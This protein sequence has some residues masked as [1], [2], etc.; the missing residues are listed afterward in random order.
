MNILGIPAEQI[1]VPPSPPAMGGIPT[2]LQKN[3][4]NNEHHKKKPPT[5]TA[6]AAFPTAAVRRHPIWGEDCPMTLRRG[7]AAM[8]GSMTVRQGQGSQH[9]EGKP[10]R[11]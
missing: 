8:A 7:S 3:G 6:A 1:H 10:C 5:H 2:L 11:R 4:R 9:G